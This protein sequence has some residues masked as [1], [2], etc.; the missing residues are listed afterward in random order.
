MN[1][2]ITVLRVSVKV[3]DDS[4]QGYAEEKKVGEGEVLE[5]FLKAKK[6]DDQFSTS[7]TVQKFFDKNS[8]F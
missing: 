2:E 5:D 1:I 4:A 8:S 6:M 7:E 3:T